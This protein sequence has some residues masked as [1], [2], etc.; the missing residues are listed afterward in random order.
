MVNV[1]QLVNKLPPS[2][3]GVGDYAI[4]LARALREHEHIECG[5]VTASLEEGGASSIDGFAVAPLRMRTPHALCRQLEELYSKGSSSDGVYNVLL[6]FSSY[7]FHRYGSPMWLVKSLAAW[8]DMDPYR[9]RLIVMFHELYADGMPWQRVFWYSLVQRHV[10]RKLLEVC[11][12]AFTNLSSNAEWIR[13][14]IGDRRLP[15]VS[16]PVMSNVGE[17]DG[18]LEFNNRERWLAIFGTRLSRTAVYRH[19]SGAI[20]QICR[21]HNISRILDIGAPLAERP[22]AIEVPI[23]ELGYL[24]PGEVSGNLKKCMIGVLR[25]PPS[26]LG[27]SGVFAAYSAHG[28]ASLC[29]G[30]DEKAPDIRDGLSERTQFLTGRAISNWDRGLIEKVGLGAHRWYEKHNLRVHAAAYGDAIRA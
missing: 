1:V 15:I 16:L 9:R 18:L 20:S 29:L 3:D 17:P 23:D 26:V 6:Q 5:F 13:N 7:G 25:Y 2:I 14:A 28:L 12:S 27:K 21:L 11:S 22:S 10:L 19:H 8:K 30:F 24:S 4:N